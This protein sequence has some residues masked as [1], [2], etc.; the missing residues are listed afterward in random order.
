LAVSGAAMNSRRASLRR[1]IELLPL[2]GLGPTLPAAL[3]GS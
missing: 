3:A 1:P 2:L